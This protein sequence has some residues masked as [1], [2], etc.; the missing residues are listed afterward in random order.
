[1]HSNCRPSP[2]FCANR[3]FAMEFHW[4]DPA[5]ACF[6]INQDVFAYL[7]DSVKFLGYRARD[8]HLCVNS[9]LLGIKFQEH[10]LF[11]KSMQVYRACDWESFQANS[12]F[13]MK[14]LFTFLH[15]SSPNLIENDHNFVFF[16]HKVWTQ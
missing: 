7:L 11:F 8:L 9:Q 10:S 12:R 16:E 5:P 15:F 1:M 4:P 6:F 2:K 13:Y 3:K 14:V